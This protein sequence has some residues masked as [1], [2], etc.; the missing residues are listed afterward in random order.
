MS[1]CSTADYLRSPANGPRGIAFEC[2]DN[3]HADVSVT[4]SELKPFCIYMLCCLTFFAV[5]SI[6]PVWAVNPTNLPKSACALRLGNLYPFDES[7]RPR[8]LVRLRIEYRETTQQLI[9][10][11]QLRRRPTVSPVAVY[12]GKPIAVEAIGKMNKEELFQFV[13]GLSRAILEASNDH[14]ELKRINGYGGEFYDLHPILINQ[15]HG[16]EDRIKELEDAIDSVYLDAMAEFAFWDSY[17]P[18]Q[19]IFFKALE[20]ARK[21]NSSRLLP[22]A[23]SLGDAQAFA[24][25]VKDGW[26]YP[27]PLSHI[28]TVSDL[29]GSF[30]QKSFNPEMALALDDHK[31]YFLLGRHQGGMGV[32]VREQ[33][34]HPSIDVHTHSENLSFS[35]GDINGY[36]SQFVNASDAEQAVW[37]NRA[38]NF[39]VAPLGLFAY[40]NNSA[41]K[42]NKA[43]RD[44]K[45]VEQNSI[46]SRDWTGNVQS[47]ASPTFDNEHDPAGDFITR[48]IKDGAQR[49][50]LT[51]AS[52]DQIEWI[53]WTELQRL[54]YLDVSIDRLP[55]IFREAPKP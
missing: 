8:R 37:I 48:A 42:P 10:Q 20:A 11:F 54:G 53:A 33:F 47:S 34:T 3:M 55:E 41:Q 40:V 4:S 9:D 52:G 1:N 16:I 18:L 38:R 17:F 30:I 22:W 5:A 26:R 51:F 45:I 49:L 39:V 13:L 12:D 27:L 23:K 14:P 46:V 19:N 24:M 28:P 36:K 43:P 29:A 31:P 6:D 21:K 35:M 32:S 50:T 2:V 25:K 15:I 44:L 7:G